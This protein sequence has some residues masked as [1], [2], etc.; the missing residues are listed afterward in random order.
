LSGGGSASAFAAVRWLWGELDRAATTWLVGG[1]VRDG[2]LGIAPGDWDLATA[3]EPPRVLALLRGRGWPL[4]TRGARF[5][6]VGVHTRVGVVDVVT[7]RAEGDYAD[8]RHPGRVHWVRRGEV[9]LR[10]RDF[11]VNALAL[12]RQG[13]VVDVVGGRRDLEAR[14]LRTVGPAAERIREDPLRAWRAV[15][16]LAYAPGDWNWD[17][18]LAAAVAAAAEAARAVAPSRVGRELAALMDRPYPSRALRAAGEAGLLPPWPP[19]RR[20]CRLPDAVLRWAAVEAVWG[21]PGLVTRVGLPRA[22]VR[23]VARLRGAL[24]GD[25]RSPAL[26]ERVACLAEWLGQPPP[27]PLPI[28]GRD[29]M[30]R[31]GIPPG[32]GV[33]AAL[34][35]ARAWVA[36]QS[37]PPDR[38]AV[39][40]YLARTGA[41]PRDE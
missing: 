21:W 14:R 12:T 39:L 29:V 36:A 35:R 40:A 22:V 41:E 18:A 27:V 2:L 6:H 31:L 7:F 8:Q 19:E 38:E 33:G 16:F 25:A 11:T 37:R 3:L 9:D 4:D 32:P 20:L 17:P 24:A 34:R 26:P 28:T 5:G 10:R 30:E 1:A 23:E 13:R 15:R